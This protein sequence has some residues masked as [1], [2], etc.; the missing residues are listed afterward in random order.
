MCQ[1]EKR[2]GLHRTG[3][4]AKLFC[5]VLFFGPRRP[6]EMDVFVLVDA[7][8][9]QR[10]KAADKEEHLNGNG[11]ICL[12]LQL[13]DRALGRLLHMRAG[14]YLHVSSRLLPY[15]SVCIMPKGRRSTINRAT[16][17]WRLGWI[18]PPGTRP[19]RNAACKAGIGRAWEPAKSLISRRK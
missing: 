9:R 18:S 6:T 19:R 3:L 7:M 13:G 2:A 8:G 12:A 10:T 16:A 15:H 14:V 4:D 17:V 11:I 1:R 5:S